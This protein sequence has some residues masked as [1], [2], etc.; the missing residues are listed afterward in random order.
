[1]AKLTFRAAP[2]LASMVILAVGLVGSAAPGGTAAGKTPPSIFGIQSSTDAGSS[3]VTGLSGYIE[4][5]EHFCIDGPA[6]GSG[7]MMDKQLKSMIKELG[8]AINGSLSDSEQIAEVI[9]R[10]K[11]GRIRRIRCA[12]GYHRLQRAPRERGRG[13]ACRLSVPPP[14]SQSRSQDAQ[15]LKA[16]RISVE[17]AG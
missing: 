2:S 13:K 12:G 15:F 16:L 6:K 11:D 7:E 1:M 4:V 3:G 5:C 9:S 8:E 14:I 17:E 10:I